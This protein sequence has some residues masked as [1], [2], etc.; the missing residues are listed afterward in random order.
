MSTAATLR[1][2]KKNSEDYSWYPTT[3]EQIKCITDDILKLNK[4]FDLGIDND[5]E[6]KILDIGAGDG[7]ILTSINGALSDQMYRGVD[8]LA[9]EKASVHT[10]EYFKKNITLIGSEFDET[11]LVSKKCSIAVCN[12]PYDDFQNWLEKIISQL[13]FGV[14]YA[15][16]PV[17]WVKDE[18]IQ[19]AIKERGIKLTEVLLESDFLNAE[20]RAN[21][22]VNV[23]RFSFVDLNDSSLHLSEE[24]IKNR[25]NKVC[26]CT[27]GN[28]AFQRFIEDELCIKKTT[29]KE[30]HRIG[31]FNASIAETIA[32]ESLFNENG[33]STE[34]VKSKGLLFALL[35][36]YERD[37]NHSLDQYK[38]IGQIDRTLLLKL[39]VDT[40]SIQK[41]VKCELEGI[42]NV[43]WSMLINNLEAISQK[44]T[45]EKRTH[46]EDTLKKNSLDF[47][48]K[49]AI[50]VI[51]Y[52]VELANNMIEDSLIEVFKKLTNES[53]VTKHYK[54]NKHMY[55]D[56]WRHTKPNN[57]TRFILDYRFI[58]NYRYNYTGDKLNDSA[59][60]FL[61]DIIVA[62]KL[63]GYSQI[64]TTH[65]QAEVLAGKSVCVYGHG[66]DGKEVLLLD[67][68]FYKNGNRH[69]RMNQRAMLTLN[70]TVSRLL[71]WV[72]SKEEFEDETGQEKPIDSSIWEACDTMKLLPSEVTQQIEFKTAA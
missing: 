20:R 4:L 33:K 30:P 72:R 56:S 41:A 66:I 58:H 52:A 12:P 14:F 47:N 32:S 42:R 59:Y 57:D 27:D 67:I 19:L 10:N 53:S 37:L 3:D 11:N 18:R 40:Y 54:S 29:V 63:L 6:I 21:T 5:K 50:Y 26:L 62:F 16:V 7:R 70:V 1:E 69:I 51:S 13:T 60:N 23:I 64:R 55:F 36:N 65:S 61:G 43:Y 48:Y 28:D 34:L 17:R 9:I 8:M 44:L 31:S 22:K 15:V 46:L 39:N 38:L 25:D 71:G 68:K 24:A 49:N 35:D 45:K 2:L